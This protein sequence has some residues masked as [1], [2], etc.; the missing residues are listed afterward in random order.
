MSTESSA[1]IIL[2]NP[3][4]DMLAL[5]RVSNSKRRPNQWDLPGGSLEEGETPLAGAVRE[6]LEELGRVVDPESL[7]ELDVNDPSS[8]RRR[9]F[10]LGQVTSCQVVVDPNEH[11]QSQWMAPERALHAFDY[12]PQ[13]QAIQYAIDQKLFPNPISG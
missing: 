9:H 10:F 7:K 13:K 5:R 6:A 11:D 12:E 1:N 2:I 8:E 3:D 4:G